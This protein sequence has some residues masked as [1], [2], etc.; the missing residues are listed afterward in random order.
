MYA[1]YIQAQPLGEGRRGLA[2]A[3]P[4][5]LSL[6]LLRLALPLRSR[7]G[8]RGSRLGTR[9]VSPKNLQHQ[10][11]SRRCWAATPRVQTV[12]LALPPHTSSPR[13]RGLWAAL[14][15]S[16]VAALRS[17]CW[18][19][20]PATRPPPGRSGQPK[21]CGANRQGALPGQ[22]FPAPA[23]SHRRA[24]RHPSPHIHVHMPIQITCT[25]SSAC[26]CCG[27]GSI[28]ARA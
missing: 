16:A 6:P 24:T 2:P 7:M 17:R 12:V 25:Q 26:A 11:S 13:L 1:I 8:H 28:C 23:P 14:R 5:T 27:Y 21:H 20:V 9:G 10:A 4:N 3:T 15:R 18:V 19:A 22:G